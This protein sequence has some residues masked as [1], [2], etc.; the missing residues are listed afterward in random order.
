MNRAR[1][2]FDLD[3]TLLDFHRAE[4]KAIAAVFD[5]LGIAPDEELLKRYSE[6]NLSCWEKLELGEMTRDEVKTTRF[7]LLFAEKGIHA[8]PAEAQERYETRLARGHYFIPGAPE[9]LE[10]LSGSYDLYLVSNGMSSVQEGRLASADISRYFR[11]IFISELLGAD[12][13]SK[14]FFERCF[15]RIPGLD[16]NRTMIIGDSLS[17]DIRGGINAGIK[18]CWFNPQQRSPRE[19]IRPDYTVSSLAELPALLENV[20]G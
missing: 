17:S 11:D 1:L 3:D 2:L 20:F 15:E 18:T 6:I 7:E 19:D 12:K 9:L 16:R 4:R 5:S 10:T 14:E 8:S 13:P